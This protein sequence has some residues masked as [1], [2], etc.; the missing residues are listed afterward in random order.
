MKKL[1]VI[2]VLGLVWCGTANAGL[3]EP[4]KNNFTC[5]IGGLEGYKEA[6]DYKKK[7]PKDNTV[8]YLACSNDGKFSWNWTGDKKLKSIHKKSFKNCTKHSNDRGTGECFLFSINDKIVWDFSNSNAGSRELLKKKYRKQLEENF[9]PT[10]EENKNK[11]YRTRKKY[12]YENKKILKNII[13]KDHPTN[14][15]E[16]KFIKEAKNLRS[17]EGQPMNRRCPCKALYRNFDAYIYHAYYKNADHKADTPGSLTKIEIVVNK[18]YKGSA[19]ARKHALK[20]AKLVGQ[21]PSFL[22]DKGIGR[23]VIHPGKRR[24]VAE[25]GNGVFVVYPSADWYVPFLTLIHEAAHIT[26]DD[27]IIHHSKWKEAVAK[28]GKYITEY[29]RVDEYEDSAETV[30]FWVALRCGKISKSRKKRILKSIPN[31]IKFLDNMNFDTDPMVC[32]K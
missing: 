24:W 21:L 27:K 22:R 3:N 1:L 5:T 13:E 28:D 14:F 29:A 31:R 23:I 32:K 6:Q 18:D 26:V 7:N 25:S 15:I 20:Y 19:K 10:E 16:L 12:V 2:V 4:G 30:T 8:V 17:P 9:Y 11:E